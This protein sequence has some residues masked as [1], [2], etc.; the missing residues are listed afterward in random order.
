MTGT[1]GVTPPRP[2]GRSGS[3][4]AGWPVPLNGD[5]DGSQQRSVD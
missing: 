2:M 4:A 3:Y 5:L 1:A